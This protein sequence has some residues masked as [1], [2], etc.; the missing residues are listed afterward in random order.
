[1]GADRTAAA[2]SK[3][4]T[5]TTCTR[6]SK[7]PEWNGVGAANRCTLARYAGTVWQVDHD[8]QP[9]STVAE[10]WYLGQ[11]VIALIRA[12]RLCQE[13]V[14]IIETTPELSWIMITSAVETVANRWREVKDSPLD[15]LHTSRPNLEE[16]LREYG[17]DDLVLLVAEEIAPYMGA[18]K[19]LVDFLIEFVP[20]SPSVRPDAFAQLSWEIKHL[21]R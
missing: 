17:G 21:K 4:E 5:W 9:F 8:L 12:A 19:T 15:K 18:T 10:V 6:S 7:A 13:A 1:M 2:E 16:K 20:P 14:W 11:D 3:N